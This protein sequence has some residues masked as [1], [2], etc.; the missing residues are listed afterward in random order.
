MARRDGISKAAPDESDS[1]EGDE[2]EEEEDE[3]DRE[4]SVDDDDVGL[5]LVEGGGVSAAWFSGDCDAAPSSKSSACTKDQLNVKLGPS[6]TSSSP[7]PALAPE[8]APGEKTLLAPSD[9][10]WSVGGLVVIE[11]RVVA[12]CA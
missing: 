8:A 1:E 2:D 4:E 6:S 3:G 7:A 10:S 5:W 11:H 9:E 12:C